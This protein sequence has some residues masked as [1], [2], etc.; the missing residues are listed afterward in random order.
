MFAV[1][2]PA[3]V[4]SNSQLSITCVLRLVHEVDTPVRVQMW[5]NAPTQLYGNNRITLREDTS[6]NLIYKSILHFSSVSFSD[7]GLYTCIAEIEPIG[8]DNSTVIGNPRTSTR[9]NLEICKYGATF[10]ISIEIFPC[11]FECEYPSGL[12]STI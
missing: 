11:S 12:H 2:D 6:M 9:I 10:N 5:W 1:L 3:D 7:V 8:T 4:L